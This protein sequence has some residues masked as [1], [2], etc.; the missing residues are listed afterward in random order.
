[1]PGPTFDERVAANLGELSPAELRVVR[2]FQDNREHVLVASAAEL[3]QRA[4]TS[5]AT[6]VRA[7]RA[8][9]YSGLDEMRRQLAAELRQSLSPASRL[10][11]TLEAV[12]DD[13]RSAFD[14]TLDIHHKAIAD[15]RRDISPV[16]FKAAVDSLVGARRVFVFGIGP[17]SALADYF[18]IQLRRFGLASG[19]LRHTGLLLADDLQQIAKGDL[20][21][22][23]AYS[24][25]YAELDAVIERADRLGIRK[26]LL[27]DTLGP[28]LRGRVDQ[29]LPVAR[30]HT[31]SLS[32]HSATL[33]LMEALLVGVAAQRPAETVASLELL[34]ELRA[35]IA[36][37]AMELPISSDK[38]GRERRGAKTRPARRR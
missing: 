1:M 6:V 17:S 20:V 28:V 4:G 36:G 10:V 2:F 34:N 8:M 29:V 21:V 27:T 26:V 31:D 19:V 13:L 7:T 14:T 15:L 23:L 35:R 25:I 11:R 3:A 37:R 33:A 24:R 30:G 18:A 12:G 16:L 22:I 5:D 32:M 9:G 38:R